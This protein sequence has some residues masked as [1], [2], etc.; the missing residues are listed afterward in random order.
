LPHIT[1][2]VRSGKS[3]KVL[4]AELRNST[5]HAKAGSSKPG[6]IPARLMPIWQ[7]AENKQLAVRFNMLDA[8]P[9]GRNPDA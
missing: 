7:T 1:S 8:A 3:L 9:A 2:F 5:Q 6:A 4:W